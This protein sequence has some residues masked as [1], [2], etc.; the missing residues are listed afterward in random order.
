MTTAW[1]QPAT[2]DEALALRREHGED[3]LVVAGG[4]FI[5]IL[6]STGFLAPPP[7]F[8]ALRDVAG[9]GEVR[10]E[11]DGT[12]V[13]GAL[14]THRQV[15]THPQVLAGWPA[16][17]ACLRLVANERVRNQA[18][19]GGVLADADYAS[20]PPALLQV[21]GAEAVLAGLEGR[22]AV[23]V[24]RL[25]VDHYT[26]VLT[27]GELLVEVRLPP[28]PAVAAYRKFRSRHAEDRPCVGVALA[29]ARTGDGRL[30]G[31]RV[32]VGAVS[33]RPVELPEACALAEGQP[34]SRELAEEVAQAYAVGIDPLDD[35]R[36]SAAYRRRIIAVEVRRALEAAA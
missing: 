8:L 9:L 12:L 10:V 11:D 5:G 13:L 24:D 1:L 36:G 26:T 28:S 17:A 23:T 30:S 7:A 16:L 33:G 29:A 14:A 21:L 25:I 15:E 6:L 27:P 22:R 3:A 35:A 34:M 20:D 31:V 32:A 4:T 19:I 2:L 18:T